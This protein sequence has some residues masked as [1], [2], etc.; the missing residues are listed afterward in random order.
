MSF[1]QGLG[2]NKPLDFSKIGYDIDFLKENKDEIKSVFD[3]IKEDAKAKAEERKESPLGFLT[4]GLLGALGVP[5]L[6]DYIGAA[7]KNENLKELTSSYFNGL[8]ED[9]TTWAK[10]ENLI[11]DIVN[12]VSGDKTI[13]TEA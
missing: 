4:N 8:K 11:G 3:E 12:T 1:I 10:E 7:A 6:F 5:S 9:I 2:N 13:E